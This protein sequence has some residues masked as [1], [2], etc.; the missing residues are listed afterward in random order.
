MSV[1]GR[2]LH[3]FSVPPPRVRDVHIGHPERRPDMATTQFTISVPAELHASV[4]QQA[5]RENRT[6]SGQIR[7]WIVEAMRRTNGTAHTP[8][9]LWINQAKERLATM[10]AEKARLEKIET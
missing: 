10:R 8:P 5:K 7:H 6:V 3:R 1:M 2:F 9:S 4:V